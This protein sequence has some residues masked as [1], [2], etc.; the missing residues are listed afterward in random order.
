MSSAHAKLP[1]A[2]PK[3]RSEDN[4]VRSCNSPLAT[5]VTAGDDAEAPREE[6]EDKKCSAVNFSH[7]RKPEISY[8]HNIAVADRHK[9]N[10]AEI[11]GVHKLADRRAVPREIG[12]LVCRIKIN[13]GKRHLHGDDHQHHPEQ[14]FGGRNRCVVHDL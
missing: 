9:R 3:W 14:E 5:C 12:S 8:R 2:S 4:G 1:S 11:N 7:C 13:A 10:P 6:S